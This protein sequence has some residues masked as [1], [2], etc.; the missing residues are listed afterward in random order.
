LTLQ[1]GTF[2][3]D[4]SYDLVLVNLDRQ[5]PL[6]LVAP[7]AGSTGKI[8]LVSGLLSDQRQEVVDDFARVVLY[9]GAVREQDGWIAMEFLGAQSCEGV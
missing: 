1:C 8:L 2:A 6:Q 3:A 9:D 7:L 5:T 4:R